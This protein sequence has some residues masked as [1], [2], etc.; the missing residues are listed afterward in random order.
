MKKSGV[1]GYLTTMAY[2]E[3]RKIPSMKIADNLLV[4]LALRG[5]WNEYLPKTQAGD[6]ELLKAWCEKLG[7]KT[8]L[9]TY[10]GKYYGHMQGI[11]HTTP[12]ALA[13]FIK[14]AR[15]YIF[16]LYIECES[17]VLICNSRFPD[18]MIFYFSV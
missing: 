18:L 11:P 4:M 13:S 14:R 10:P 1:P 8:W 9:W 17:D 5:P 2:G 6:M 16:G 15:P 3:Y 7:Q 12:R